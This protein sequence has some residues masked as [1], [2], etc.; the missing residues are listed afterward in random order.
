[1]SFVVH[2]LSGDQIDKRIENVEHFPRSSSLGELIPQ[3]Q[4]YRKLHGTR[5]KF[6]SKTAQE[7]R[8]PEILI[9][10]FDVT[11][12]WALEVVEQID[13]G[14]HSRCAGLPSLP[15]PSEHVCT[16]SIGGRGSDRPSTDLEDARPRRTD[17]QPDRGRAKSDE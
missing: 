17:R 7:S 15:R 5:I 12:P 9:T 2:L 14:S 16:M 11:Y 3:P 1:M 4:L 8:D 10:H 13:V 6:L